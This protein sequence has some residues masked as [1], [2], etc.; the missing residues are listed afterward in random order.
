MVPPWL[1]EHCN[2]R[3][4]G[5]MAAETTTFLLGR[6]SGVS[7]KTKTGSLLVSNLCDSMNAARLD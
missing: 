6:S 2:K 3:S 1:P 4:L 7:M 5:E